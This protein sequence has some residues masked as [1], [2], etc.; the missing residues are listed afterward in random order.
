M[1][2]RIWIALALSLL[3]AGPGLSRAASPKAKK[4]D[5]RIGDEWVYTV[6]ANGHYLGKRQYTVLGEGSFR[7][8]PALKIDSKLIEVRSEKVKVFLEDSEVFFTP[9]G[10]WIGERRGPGR[11]DYAE[12]PLPVTLWP[13]EV[14]KKWKA[15][16]SLY[17]EL[18]DLP[19][20]Y[21]RFKVL[22]YGPLTVPAGTFEA[23]HL[24]RRSPRT[25]MN[26]WYAPAVKN[27]IKY[28]GVDW[29][30]DLNYVVELESFDLKK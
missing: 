12:P 9:K 8:Q 1:N 14:G 16:V 26:Y 25:T 30:D 23:F 10:A 19:H 18:F 24:E 7:G 13:L 21:N 15:T 17:F 29:R 2:K 4:P 5:T 27:I 11:M 22:S 3:L 28:Q 6:T 20:E